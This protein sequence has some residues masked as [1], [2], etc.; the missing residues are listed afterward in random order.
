MKKETVAAALFLLLLAG[1]LWNAHVLREH[2]RKTE[3]RVTLCC[4]ALEKGDT[5]TAAL[6]LEAA[7][8]L[9]LSRDTYVRVVL[10]HAELDGVNAAFYETL[11][12]LGEERHVSALFACQAL[13]ERLEEIARM[14]SVNL[15]SVW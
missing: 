3:E 4:E 5:K 8:S 1:T 12:H 9:W 6:D 13:R 2:V 11:E 7:H 10:R 14:D 15:G